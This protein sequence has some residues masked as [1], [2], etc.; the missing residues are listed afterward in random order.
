MFGLLQRRRPCDH[1]HGRA[2]LGPAAALSSGGARRGRGRPRPVRRQRVRRPEAIHA[3]IKKNTK[4]VAVNHGSNVIGTVQP[5]ARSARSAA[6]TAS[7]LWS[8]LADRRE[9]AD[10]RAGDEYR[11]AVLHRPQ[12][13][14][15]FDRHRRN[16]RAGG[17][18]HPADAGRRHRRAVRAARAPR[19]VP[20]A[21]GIR[22]AERDRDGGPATRA[23]SGCRSRASRRSTRTRCG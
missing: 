15:G 22:D 1:D 3:R 13:A 16:V 8:M 4:V 18:E 19:R 12:V 23:S 11:R 14:D 2:Q 10:R 7:T 6:S 5:A 17:R 20:V 9:D 21:H